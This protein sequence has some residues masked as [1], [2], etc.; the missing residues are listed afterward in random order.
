MTTK[1]RIIFLFVFLILQSLFI[2]LYLKQERKYL[3]EYRAFVSS[4]EIIAKERIYYVALDIIYNEIANNLKFENDN[5]KVL[6]N[7]S[8]KKMTQLDWDKK[9]FAE[10]QSLFFSITQNNKNLNSDLENDLSSNFSKTLKKLKANYSNKINE[11]SNLKNVLNKN[12]LKKLNLLFN[13]NK[14][15]VE[16]YSLTKELKKNLINNAYNDVI[17]LLDKETEI[18]NKFFISQMNLKKVLKAIWQDDYEEN[19]LNYHDEKTLKK[20]EQTEFEIKKF[21]KFSQFIIDEEIK[22]LKFQILIIDKIKLKK[23]MVVENFKPLFLYFFSAIFFQI[24]LYLA[25]NII[26]ELKRRSNFF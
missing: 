18:H 2:F 20:V 13:E 23:T 9:W 10:N 14:I 15:Y 8:K 6:G 17:S 3:F 7:M 21:N 24:I 25:V 1:N 19:S 12:E 16:G 11:L 5:V 22:F 4:N 26:I